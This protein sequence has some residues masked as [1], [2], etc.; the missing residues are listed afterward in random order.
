MP[1][2]QATD[3][4]LLLSSALML[5]ACAVGPEYRRPDV[6]TPAQY[7]EAARVTQANASGTGSVARDEWWRAFDDPLLDTLE[8]QVRVSNQN[9]AA[10]EAAYREAQSAISAQ[11]ASFWPAVSVNG[12][13]ERSR[14]N[15]NLQTTTL[16]MTDTATTY[17]AGVSGSWALDV[18][19]RLRRSLENARANAA[20]SAADLAAATLSNQ[21]LLASSY[22]QLREADSELKLLNETLSDYQ[23]AAQVTLNR[24]QAGVAARSDVLQANTQ[25]A[26]TQ[27]DVAALKLQRAQLEH[28]I[29]SLVGQP[30]G[31][32][33]LDANADWQPHVPE[34]P[35]AV[36]SDL[37]RQR[38][39]VLAA[40][41]RVAAASANI[42]IQKTAYFPSLT[43]TA[44]DGYTART[45]TNLFSP[46]NVAWNTAAAVTGTLFD[47][48]ATSAKVRS[49]RAAYDAAVAQ[50]R[51]TVLDAF[52]NVEDQLA[53]AR[54]LS[55]ETDARVQASEAALQAQQVLMNQYTAGK[56][57]YTEVVS[58][59][60]SALSAQRSLAQVRLARQTNAVSLMTALGG[61]GE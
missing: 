37:L 57:S 23:K 18:W 5:S 11:R 41:R 33:G 7:K 16:T 14:Q 58:V 22:L 54:W 46:A 38:P 28:A 4:W 30:A 3:L 10:A 19:G 32:F 25:V 1:H 9:I 36:P 56:V 17:S 35:G 45:L 13:A 24:Y 50:Y 27:A 15:K 29:A 34:V 42:G 48:G 31:D 26:N 8:Q 20:A 12:G 40:E 39:D 21:G 6:Q 43:L 52:K 61:V 59:Q 2:D 60:A 44:S 51:Q 53:G 47:A 55:D 49:A